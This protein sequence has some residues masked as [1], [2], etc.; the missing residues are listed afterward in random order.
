MSGNVM[1]PQEPGRTARSDLDSRRSG[2]EPTA[3]SGRLAR[4]SSLRRHRS[5]NDLPDIRD[6][7]DWQVRT[8][9][10]FGDRAIGWVED[11][12][13]DLAAMKVRYVLV[14]LERNAV[15][16]HRDHRILVP[17]GVGRLDEKE[18][19]MRLDS[20]TGAQLVSIP[21]FRPGRLTRNY[22]TILRKRFGSPASG[23]RALGPRLT[24]DLYDHE[25]FDDS[26]FW[27]LRATRR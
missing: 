10:S 12:I 11:L 14:R 22:E 27:R 15:A 5:A 17:V 26:G 9:A 3:S 21:E 20:F 13:V 25:H 16:L 19:H 18:D 6:I 7:R 8:A 23:P 24:K 1:T 4:F 2:A